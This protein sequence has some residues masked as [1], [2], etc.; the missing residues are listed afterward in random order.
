M[1]IQPHY[2]ESQVY[3]ARYKQYL[4]R[5]LSLVKQH[6]I[7]I[8]KN[9][10]KSVQTGQVSLD[11]RSVKL[12]DNYMFLICRVVLSLQQRVTILNIMESLELMLLKSR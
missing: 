2:K 6:V 10:T 5:A 12:Y 8:L 3:L 11:P 4:S 1:C 9:A 7:N